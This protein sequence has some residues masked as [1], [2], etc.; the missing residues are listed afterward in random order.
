[1]LRRLFVQE[2]HEAALLPLQADVMSRLVRPDMGHSAF[3]WG[4]PRALSMRKDRA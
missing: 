1:M 4:F 3:Y 2:R